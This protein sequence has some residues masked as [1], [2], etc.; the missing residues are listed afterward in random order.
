M[1]AE[2]EE[3]SDIETMLEYMD[4]YGSDRRRTADILRRFRHRP[5]ERGDSHGETHT[6]TVY[7]H[8]ERTERSGA[9]ES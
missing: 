5:Y 4:V 3:M 7:G 2:E 8:A 9:K 6:G 1:A